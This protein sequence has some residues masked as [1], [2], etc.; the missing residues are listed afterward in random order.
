[1]IRRPPR[2][3]LFPYTTLFRSLAELYGLGAFS[4]DLDDASVHFGFDLIHQLHRFHHA[5]DLSLLDDIAL[6]DVRIG[7]RRRRS[8]KGSDDG[9]RDGHLP[10]RVSRA[11]VCEAL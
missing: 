11:R 10:D 1:M 4:K 5:Q 6:L 9:G 3:T 2:S 8:V 7:V